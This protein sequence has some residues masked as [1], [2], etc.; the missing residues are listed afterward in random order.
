MGYLDMNP[1]NCEVNEQIIPVYILTEI[2]TMKGGADEFFIAGKNLD[3]YTDIKELK[4][5][6]LTLIKQSK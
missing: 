2:S 3:E 1:P 5:E 4:E 6:I